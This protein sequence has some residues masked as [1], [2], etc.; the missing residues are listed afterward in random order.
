MTYFGLFYSLSNLTSQS[1]SCHSFQV[2]QGFLVYAKRKA[3]FAWLVA[4]G[5]DV[6]AF[7]SGAKHP[8]IP[9]KMTR[10]S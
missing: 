10:L 9:H 1:R 2:A 5:A 7:Y 6:K 4:V 3:L 8:M